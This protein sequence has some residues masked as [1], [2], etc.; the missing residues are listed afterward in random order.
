V[1]RKLTLR[2]LIVYGVPA[3]GLM[4]AMVGYFLLVSPQKSKATDLESQVTGAQAAL[5]AAHQKPVKPV[6]AHAVELFH[7][8]TAMPDAADIPNLLLNLVRVAQE[9]KITLNSVSPGAQVNGSGYA[10]VPINVSVG[11]TF[12]EVSDFLARLRKQVAMTNHSVRA[13]GRLIIANTVDFS[14]SDAGQISATLDL[15]AFV[16]NSAAPVP[17]APPTTPATTP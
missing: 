10:L 14:S 15:D 8:T 11:G 12:P 16:Y 9:S 6:T 2:E 5:V 3:L 4:L 1:K 13:T 17:T 7:L